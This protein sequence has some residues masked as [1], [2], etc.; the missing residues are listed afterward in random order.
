MQQLITERSH[1]HWAQRWT[2]CQAECIPQQ[3]T[4]LT[5]ALD[6]ALEILD[7]IGDTFFFSGKDV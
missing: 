3:A 2:E 5:N 1:C 4:V 6:G 7:I